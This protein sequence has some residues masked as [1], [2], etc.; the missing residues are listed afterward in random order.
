[1]SGVSD[2]WRRNSVNRQR[3]EYRAWHNHLFGCDYCNGRTGRY[4]AQGRELHAD[5]AVPLI[6][7]QIA[8]ERSLSDRRRML[9][10]QRG[11]LVPQIKTEVWRIWDA[12]Q[13]ERENNR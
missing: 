2:F 1:M 10:A 7:Q 6:G 3:P 12:M 9:A 11:Y 8:R 5:Y 13:A 4:C